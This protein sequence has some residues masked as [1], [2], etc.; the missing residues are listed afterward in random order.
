MTIGPIVDS[1]LHVYDTDRLSYP[2]IMKVEPLKGAFLPADY[3]RE[4]RDLAIDKMVFVEVAIADDQFIEEA[5]WVSREA[6]AADP[7]IAAIVAMAP[8]EKGPAVEADL[9]RLAT[10]PLVRGVRRLLENRPDDFCLQPDFIAGVRCL[11]RYD[12]SFDICIRHHQLANATALVQECPEM[13][14]VLD[15][16]GKPDIR[17]GAWQAWASGIRALAALPNVWCKISGVITEADHRNWTA[18]DVRPYIA[19]AI[20]AFGFDRVMFG[21]DWPVS[22]LTN[23]MPQWVEIVERTVAGASA[24]ERQKLFHDNA[25]AFYRIE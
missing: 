4:C 3:R 7:G 9:E 13:R 10:I 8:V 22:T 23:T 2:F 20:E 17:G 21:G 25:L 19:H 1:H 16:I 14:F 11:A 15:H 5:E 24:G 18:D 12:F 6:A